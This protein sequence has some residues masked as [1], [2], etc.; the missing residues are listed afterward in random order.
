VITH[1][2]GGADYIAAFEA[3]KS[4]RSGKVVLDWS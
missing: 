3:M 2:Y 1:H 4:G